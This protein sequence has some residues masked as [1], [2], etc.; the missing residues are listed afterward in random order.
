MTMPELSK[1]ELEVM[2]V[3]WT[4]DRQS[5]REIHDAVGESMDWEY[6]TTRTVL[7]RLIKKGAVAKTDF[8]GIQLYEPL[9]TRARGLAR[10]A[11]EFAERVMEVDPSLVVPL[12]S[13]AEGLT[14][15]EIAEISLLLNSDG[16]ES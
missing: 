10:L 8:H 4:N 15:A 7:T 1:S 6:S 13:K 5:A 9:I 14:E 2:K 12:F 3:L 16:G 11:R